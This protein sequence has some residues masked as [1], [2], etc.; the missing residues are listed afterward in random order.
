MYKI[1]LV[2]LI[3]YML[4]WGGKSLVL[5]NIK[6]SPNDENYRSYMGFHLGIIFAVL[7]GVLRY[8]GGAV[9]CA[10]LIKE[11]IL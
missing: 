2:I 6:K 8:L 7:G 11:Y 1:L 4:R 9:L 5:S 10:Y 3:G